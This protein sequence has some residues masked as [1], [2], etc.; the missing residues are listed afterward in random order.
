MQYAAIDIS[1]KADIAAPIWVNGL[2]VNFTFIVPLNFGGIFTET[3]PFSDGSVHISF[4]L[5]KV[6]R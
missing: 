4:W 3:M 1:E 6:A 2:M 5:L